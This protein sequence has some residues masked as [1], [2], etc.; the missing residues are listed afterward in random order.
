MPTLVELSGAKYP[1][2]YKGHTI[3][4]TIGESLVPVFKNKND[5][6][7]DL[8]WWEHEG[9]R[10]LRKGNWKIVSRYDYATNTELPWELYDLQADRSETK[11]LSK[12]NTG[13]LNELIAEHRSLS[14]RVNAVSYKQLLE[15]RKTKQ[16]ENP[17]QSVNRGGR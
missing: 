4:P 17:S 15:S 16:K 1:K 2:Q 14:N 10:A 8:T 12:S 5:T 3:T 6:G 11:D 7:R 13:K 9:N